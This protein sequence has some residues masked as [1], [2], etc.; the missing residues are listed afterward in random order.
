[1]RPAMQTPVKHNV[2]D[3]RKHPWR[4]IGVVLAVALLV[5]LVL[6]AWVGLAFV[7]NQDKAHPVAAD[8]VFNY[9]LVS[10]LSVVGLPFFHWAMLRHHWLQEQRRLAGLPDD[11]NQ[12]IAAAMVAAEPLPPTRKNWRQRV[13]AA[14]KRREAAT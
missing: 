3:P 12:T 7:L 14:K 5:F 13:L 8:V 9:L 10:L 1:M 11:P 4:F 6:M 2:L